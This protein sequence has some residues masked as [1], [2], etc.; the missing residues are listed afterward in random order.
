MKVLSAGIFLFLS[1]YAAV[2]NAATNDGGLF[3]LQQARAGE[4]VYLRECSS[5]HNVN[6][7]GGEEGVALLGTAF[8]ERWA[9]QP[10][11][12]LYAVTQGTMPKVNPGG[13]SPAQY[14]QVLAY[15]L[16][17][18]GYPAGDKELSGGI[19]ELSAM[20]LPQ[21]SGDAQALLARLDGL[22]QTS[23]QKS[24]DWAH[25]RGDEGSSCLFRTR[26]D[27]C[28]QRQQAEHCLALERPNFGASPEFNFQSTPIMV[29][30]RIYTTAGNRRD[31]VAIDAATVKHCGC[32]GST[33]VNAVNTR[34]GGGSGRGVAYT[35]INGQGRIYYITPGYRLVG[36]DASTGQ[37]LKILA[38][39]ASSISRPSSIRKSIWSAIRSARA[40][41]R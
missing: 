29:K 18:N 4:S 21:P 39:A 8:L 14:R 34:R 15:M 5:C 22:V 3:T 25:V 35:E 37:P 6:L 13:L 28:G 9:N 2:T 31:A 33:K 16:L 11:S 19:A 30:G 26:P 17:A 38:T 41:H 36:L 10:L 1:A 24:V 40:R 23:S 7:A 32:T 27:Q 12:A 20:Q